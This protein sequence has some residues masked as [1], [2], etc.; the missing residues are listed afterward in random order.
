MRVELTT[1]A[2]ATQCPSLASEAAKG[3]MTPQHPR[4]TNCCTDGTTELS[5][6][7]KGW[8]DVLGRLPL[9]TRARIAGKLLSEDGAP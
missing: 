6:V 4:C 2:L 9:A 5:P 1:T 3:L 8:L 7:V